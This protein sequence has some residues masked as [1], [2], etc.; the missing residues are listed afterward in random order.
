MKRLRRWLL[1]GLTVLSLLVFAATLVLWPRSYFVSHEITYAWNPLGARVNRKVLNVASL[2]GG[3]VCD[4]CFYRNISPA[5][6][7]NGWTVD[8]YDARDVTH[9]GNIIW[10]A[11]GIELSRIRYGMPKTSVDGW[12]L[13]LQYWLI[14]FLSGLLPVWN[15]VALVRAK[16]RIP[17]FPVQ[18]S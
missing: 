5:G 6:V 2:R 17:G 9:W 7:V 8:I 12:H 15:L 13:I 18:P 16:T 14:V 10:R 1:N 3:I 11:G 4:Y